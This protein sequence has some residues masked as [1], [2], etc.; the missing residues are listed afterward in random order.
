LKRLEALLRAVVPST[1]VLTRQ[2][3]VG[4]LLDAPD[5]LLSLP[6]P[7]FRVLPPNRYRVRVGIGNRLFFNQVGFLQYGLGTWMEIFAEG[8]ADDTS[9]VV[10]I[11]CGCGRAAFPLKM[12]P[13]FTGV[14]TG[15][16]VD[17]EMIGWCDAN[18]PRDRFRFVHAD[19]YSS[20]YN[21]DGR[22]E[23]YELPLREESQELVISQSLFTHLLEEDLAQYVRESFRVLRP[24]GHMVMSTF[25][26]DHLRAAGDLGGRWSFDHRVGEAYVESPAYPEAAVAY[27]ESYLLEVC[28]RAG[29]SEAR[30]GPHYAQSLLVCRKTG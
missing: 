15:I 1:P 18:F 7:E 19:I 20:V 25:C 11:G 3:V 9:N 28:R 2:P 14:Y 29:F 17:S 5:R 27:E 4:W 24:G 8:W 22:R 16:D 12:R 6:Y 10:D 23:P 30:V 26:L 21:P 13:A